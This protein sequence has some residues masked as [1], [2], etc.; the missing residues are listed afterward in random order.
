MSDLLNSSQMTSPNAL[1]ESSLHTLRGILTT[2]KNKIMSTAAIISS[3]FTGS[4]QRDVSKDPVSLQLAC[5]FHQLLQP[6][7]RHH[8]EYHASSVNVVAATWP[9]S[10]EF[11]VPLV[12]MQARGGMLVSQ[13]SISGE[14]IPRMVVEED[15]KRGS[16][17]FPGGGETGGG[18]ERGDDPMGGGGA[19]TSFSLEKRIR[20]DAALSPPVFEDLVAPHGEQYMK[21]KET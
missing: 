1:D 2:E 5:S 21:K 19:M 9:V 14:A 3:N 7:L 17:A 13:E 20:L 6:P 16:Q 12:S 4:I 15:G 10:G 11:S 18:D 8:S